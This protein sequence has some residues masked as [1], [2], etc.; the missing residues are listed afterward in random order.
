MHLTHKNNGVCFPHVITL[1]LNHHW[2]QSTNL[3][4]MLIQMSYDCRANTCDLLLI[5][6]KNAHVGSWLN[7]QTSVHAFCNRET[8]RDNPAGQCFLDRLVNGSICMLSS[9][10]LRICMKVYMYL[11]SGICVYIYLYA[12]ICKPCVTMWICAYESAVC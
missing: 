11:Q 9:A 10:Q 1:Y 8:V 6:Y 4:P 5:W 7:M 3:I 2:F 12:Y